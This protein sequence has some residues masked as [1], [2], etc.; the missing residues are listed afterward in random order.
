[1]ATEVLLQPGA[2]GLDAELREN[3]A[4]SNYGGA[5]S[6]YVD[7]AT[8]AVR[9]RS[10]IQWDLSGL[11]ISQGSRVLFAKML[12]HPAQGPTGT[13]PVTIGA[14]RVTAAWNESQVTWNKRDSAN[15]WASAGGDFDAATAA[16]SLIDNLVRT[17][18]TTWHSFV[19]TQLVKDWLDGVHPNLGLLLKSEDDQ[20]AATT[21]GF[22]QSDHTTATER[23]ILWIE[24][25]DSPLN[26]VP[27]ANG[28]YQEWE[29][30]SANGMPNYEAVC[31][32][33]TV[34]AGTEPVELYRR[35]NAASFS[36]VRISF[37]TCGGVPP[38][39]I[40]SSVKVKATVLPYG[41]TYPAS[42]YLGIRTNGQ[43]FWDP[44]QRVVTTYTNVEAEWSTNPA[45]GQAWTAAEAN[46]LEP[47]VKA[48]PG[49]RT[50]CLCRIYVQV[51]FTTGSALSVVDSGTGA[52]QPASV[53]ASASALVA[54]E[55]G[56]P[57]KEAAGYWQEV[58]RLSTR[59]NPVTGRPEQVWLSSWVWRPGVQATLASSPDTGAGVDSASVVSQIVQPSPDAGAATDGLAGPPAVSF[60][61]GESG[62]PAEVPF[63]YYQVALGDANVGS[64]QDSL[65]LELLPVLSADSGALA[66]ESMGPILLSPTAPEAAVGREILSQLGVILPVRSDQAAGAELA[67][68]LVLLDRHILSCEIDSSLEALADGAT[69]E[70]VETDPANPTSPV[71]QA[72][73]QLNRGDLV[74]IRLGLAGV[75]LDDYGVFRI[76]Q[77]NLAA[78]N[79]A[80]RS[81]LSARDRA[82]LLLD[83][84]G[85]S[86]AATFG[87][88]PST[89]Y[90]ASV[91]SSATQK[92]YPSMVG[93]A[94]ALAARVGLGL[95]WD[96]PNY[97]LKDFTIGPEESTGAALGRV[98]EPVRVS[99]RYR[100][101]AWV[102]GENL[103]V[104]ER[105]R[106]P[107][108][109]TLD[110]RLGQVQS[111]RRSQM[112][113]VGEITVEG[114]TI[115]ER[116][117][118]RTDGE[119]KHA[120]SPSATVEVTEE[121]DGDKVVKTYV[122]RAI[123]E[124]SWD[125]I[126]ELAT[127]ETT[128]QEYENVGTEDSRWLGRVLVYESVQLDY[129]LNT[130]HPKH[131]RRERRFSYDTENRLILTTELRKSYDSPLWKLQEMRTT[132]S[133]QATPTDVRTT[134]YEWALKQPED[135]LRMRSGY[136]KSQV[137][138]GTLQSGLQLVPN[139]DE[140]WDQEED[141]S[142]PK[143]TRTFE[144]T[145]QYT[146]GSHG[147]G[148]LPRSYSNAALV[149]D[150]D[151]SDIAS[152][153]ALESGAW[154]YEIALRWPRPLAYRKG[155]RVTL[156]HLPG[157]MPDG[158]ALLTRV[159]TRFDHERSEWTHDLT[160]E[161]WRAA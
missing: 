55:G 150:S 95:I 54:Q 96:A 45:T 62:I 92:S 74:R 6:M 124:Y 115:T 98:L 87:V 112:P 79:H 44:T 13:Y 16:S 119:K 144:F 88:Q 66:A 113:L 105:G 47:M 101:D 30:N 152:N 128:H 111:I 149:S 36:D 15:N 33:P 52:E 18:S 76:D 106:G 43:D 73:L 17:A 121:P 102:D 3:A 59:R 67:R 157:S 11:S 84:Q 131:E 31:V 153:L 1:M 75:G 137:T 138:P 94:S 83:E 61:L 4:T 145:K 120:D 40:I 122:S 136:P 148:T 107:I 68:K 143:Q 156:L 34:A 129:D 53:V 142:T 12:L 91:P 155:D 125:D 109:G 110:C 151:C 127:V 114:A 5:A 24:N 70:M 69:L 139:P 23:P 2:A 38:G 21:V 32:P 46:A 118:Y 90:A 147:G 65:A 51:T 64:A 116:V 72:W 108:A 159:R 104:R 100:T 140:A 86:Y 123:D 57:D 130:G 29:A 135:E 20:A 9:K 103:V 71:A 27:V 82:A 158:E 50:F 146:G 160:L 37:Q 26:L 117:E 80:L 41:L 81:T 161:A 134:V 7:R 63:P 42:G 8:T 10:L 133:Y 35:I 48:G 141:G 58:W 77:V 22:R 89:G 49:S 56:T 14:H 60:V 99:R 28:T 132:H 25:T 19:L 154:L 97:S 93:I 39:A 126:K 85:R 78:G